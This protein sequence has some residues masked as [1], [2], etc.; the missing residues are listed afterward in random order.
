MKVRVRK[1]NI[2]ADTHL[3]NSCG[4]GVLRLEDGNEEVITEF[5]TSQG[6]M[7]EFIQ[8]EADDD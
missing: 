1:P 7:V 6:K 2:A 3:L 8:Y 4:I 5:I